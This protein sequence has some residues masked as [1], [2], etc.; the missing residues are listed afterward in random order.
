MSGAGV[1]AIRRA[2]R[3]DVPALH[4]CLAAMAAEI[5]DGA[6]FRARP[7]DLAR[8][9]F[10][11]APRFHALIAEAGAET[12]G[13]A[14][15]F[16]EFSTLRGAPGVYVQ[17]LYVAPAHRGSGLA[18]RLLGGVAAEARGWGA[19]YLKL[20][21][22]ADNARALAFY[23]RLG[24]RIDDREKPCFIGGEAFDRLGEST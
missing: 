18:A 15:F 3:Q 9:G 6:A 10:G 22:Y 8:H 23:R 20:T 13:A 14:V 7:E 12:A 24:F 11:A 16:P 1:A 19:G 4:A 2:A 5:G 17:D 21:A